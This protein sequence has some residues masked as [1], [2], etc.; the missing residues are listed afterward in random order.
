M[1][2]NV[3]D[4]HP[5]LRQTLE[6]VADKWV[7]AVLYVLSNGTKRYGELQREIGNISQ[8]MLTKSLRDLERNGLVNRKVYPVVPLIVE[9]SLTPLGES[10]NGV[11]KSLCDWSNQNFDEVEAARDKYDKQTPYN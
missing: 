11:L 4:N 5:F 8:R 10:L 7:V 6:L 2:L 9:Y 1:G 3:L